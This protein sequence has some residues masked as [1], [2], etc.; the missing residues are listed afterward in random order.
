MG[1]RGFDWSCGRVP[2][3][4]PERSP[5]PFDFA[6]GKFSGP[7]SQPT[8]S[9]VPLR[10]AEM[11][12][13]YKYSALAVAFLHFPFLAIAQLHRGFPSPPAKET[14][15]GL[16][17]PDRFMC[18]RR[19]PRLLLTPRVRRTSMQGQSALFFPLR[20][21]RHTFRK[22]ANPGAVGFRAPPKYRI[23]AS[24]MLIR[25]VKFGV[26]PRAAKEILCDGLRKRGNAWFLRPPSGGTLGV[27]SY[28]RVLRCTGSCGTRDRRERRGS[29]GLVDRWGQCDGDWHLVD[30]LHR[31]ACLQ[32]A[33]PSWL[34]V[35]DSSAV[36]HGR[37][38]SLGVRAVCSEPAETGPGSRFD[39]QPRYGRRHC[40]HP[41]HRNGCYA[42]SC[43]N[44]VCPPS[45]DPVRCA[46]H[47]VF[48]CRPDARI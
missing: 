12:A 9:L 10:S 26:S 34:S 23:I 7:G 35:A 29:L 45:C 3:G 21:Q 19:D 47:R 13:P 32:L 40:G 8:P 6:P 25:A 39:R 38:L 42:F 2:P 27:D 44:P 15:H 24:R 14:F 1:R 17:Q 36:T 48:F 5:A 18:Y 31:D 11:P 41:L 28:L 33:C 16:I 37:Y 22:F 46:G 30:A 43:R 4:P 20:I